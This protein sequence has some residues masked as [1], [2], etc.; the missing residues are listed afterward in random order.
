MIRE[1]RIA[2]R[3]KH[4]IGINDDDLAVVIKPAYKEMCLLFPE[5]EISGIKWLN[6]IP[7]I[8]IGHELIS[9]D[10]NNLFLVCA[11]LSMCWTQMSTLEEEKRSRAFSCSLMKGVIGNKILEDSYEH[12][13]SSHA[14]NRDNC[15]SYAQKMMKLWEECR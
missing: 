7:R 3:V 6:R 5:W 10:S 11:H 4:R 8:E 2:Y 1:Y 12:Q 9:I 13:I 14:N 15:L